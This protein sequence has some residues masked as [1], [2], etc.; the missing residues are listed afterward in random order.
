MRVGGMSKP[1]FGWRR[2]RG[3]GT[4]EPRRQASPR[5]RTVPSRD[6][7][8]E[9]DFDIDQIGVDAVNGC[10]AGFEEHGPVSLLGEWDEDSIRGWAGQQESVCSAA[11]IHGGACA[12]SAAAP[13]EAISIE[14]ICGGICLGRL[15]PVANSV[16]PA[17]AAH[18]REAVPIVTISR[19]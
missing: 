19:A 8:G 12:V 4:R 7:A 13:V 5:W 3:R 10:A 16:A 14:L 9:V 6:D 18:T 17:A 15:E 11:Q 1:E 2:G